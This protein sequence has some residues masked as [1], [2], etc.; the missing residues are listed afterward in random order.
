MKKIIIIV[1]GILIAV[2][3]G[4]AIWKFSGKRE[5]AP[6]VEVAPAKVNHL[7]TIAR[8][9][10]VELYSEVP[11]LDTVGSKVIFGIQKQKGRISFDLETL[12]IN[13]E[14]D[15][16]IVRLPKEKIELFESTDPHSWEVVD[17]KNLNV[18]GTSKLTAEEDNAVKRKIAAKSEARLYKDGTVARARKEGKATLERL[19][20]AFYGRP[21]IVTD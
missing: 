20:T 15:T 5:K 21:A 18:F 8:L 7:A 19:L 14:A 10:T 6:E 13:A 4:F 9:C 16:I 1:L 11:V 17:T 12:N 3:A 2:G